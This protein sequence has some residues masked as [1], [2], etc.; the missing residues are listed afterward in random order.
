M[1][2]HLKGLQEVKKKS[3]SI[4]EVAPP[5][6]KF[7]NFSTDYSVFLTEEETLTL[8]KYPHTFDF[9]LSNSHL[10]FMEKNG[11]LVLP[12]LINH[13]LCDQIV[14]EM[15]HFGEKLLAIDQKGDF[16]SKGNRLL[17][18]HGCVDMWHV[19]SI[20]QLR[21]HPYLYS[22]FAQLCKTPRLCATIERVGMKPP[23]V[24]SGDSVP[25]FSKNGKSKVFG[26]TKLELHTDL[27]PWFSAPHQPQFQASVCLRDC[28]RGGGGFFLLPG[29]HLAD[30]MNEYKR[31]Y[32]AVE[33]AVPPN[34]NEVFCPF[35]D[36]SHAKEVVEIPMKRGDLVIWNSFLPHASGLNTLSNHWRLQAFARF[37]ALDG[38]TVSSHVAQSNQAYGKL[39]K[40]WMTN[41]FKPSHF[42][43]GN[44][45]KYSGSVKEREHYTPPELS[46]LGS[47]VFLVKPFPDSNKY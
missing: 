5:S 26:Q 11:Y 19:P 7:L 22:I 14:E 35:L 30:K 16:T 45:T 9:P 12:G 32:E 39:A 15:F 29:F 20:Y 41:G 37:L 8:R 18:F 34:S 33:K 31:R 43:A 10:S 38:P 4:E 24:V 28:P 47:Q 44:R 25:G 6:K 2:Y 42:S 46:E 23:P 1:R 27:N 40:R 3:D 13:D 17:P 36:S 21:Q